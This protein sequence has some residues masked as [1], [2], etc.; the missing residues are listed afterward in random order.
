[1]NLYEF[2]L[3]SKRENCL[4]TTSQFSESIMNLYT[5]NNQEEK[6][7][8]IDEL[9][10]VQSSARWKKFNDSHQTLSM[11]F[12]EDVDFRAPSWTF[13]LRYLEKVCLILNAS[14]NFVYYCLSGRELRGRLCRALLCFLCCFYLT[15]KKR[16][17]RMVDEN[18]T[19]QGS[20]IEM[21]RTRVRTHCIGL[22]DTAL[23]MEMTMNNGNASIEAVATDARADNHK[24]SMLHS[25]LKLT[26]YAIFIPEKKSSESL[27]STSHS[28]KGCRV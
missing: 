3:V 10:K 2:A 15:W 8:I 25:R 28:Y 26:S 18:F 12:L 22:Q 9:V 14:L 4:V 5:N 7:A 27:S 13:Y 23:E 21:R 19:A 1:M 24:T 20:E 16:A 11:E 17:D 6:A